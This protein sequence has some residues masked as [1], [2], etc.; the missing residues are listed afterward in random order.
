M[1]GR[2]LV[3]DRALVSAQLTCLFRQRH[4]GAACC[5]SVPIAI[6]VLLR[7]AASDDGEERFVLTTE[8]G[9]KRTC[10]NLVI[11][12]VNTNYELLFTC[13]SML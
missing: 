6:V 5:Y 13:C 3:V 7:W 9:L 12:R 2:I 10:D 4:H 8:R 1:N 11:H